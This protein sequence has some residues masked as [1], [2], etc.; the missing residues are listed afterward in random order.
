MPLNQKLTHPTYRQT[1]ALI[2]SLSPTD[3]AD[4]EAIKRAHLA[5]RLHYS[6]DQIHRALRDLDYRSRHNLRSGRPT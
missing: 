3:Q 2:Q 1:V 4:L 6:N 5:A